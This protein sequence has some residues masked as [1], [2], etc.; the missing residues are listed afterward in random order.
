MNIPKD[1]TADPSTT[2]IAILLDDAVDKYH[3]GE[4]VFKLQSITGMKDNSNT[5]DTTK[6]SIPNLMNNF[7]SLISS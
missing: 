5:I 6:I 4:Q 2:E 7:F 3:P 1:Q